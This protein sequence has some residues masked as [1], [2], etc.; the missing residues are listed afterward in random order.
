MAHPPRLPMPDFG[1]HLEYEVGIIQWHDDFY[2][3]PLDRVRCDV[4]YYHHM[5]SHLT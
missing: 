3:Q 4:G 5:L 1:S 2:I